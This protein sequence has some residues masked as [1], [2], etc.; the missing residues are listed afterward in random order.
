MLFTQWL[1]E[2]TDR[3]LRKRTGKFAR[4]ARKVS[5]NVPA[6][7]EV[8]ESRV[9]PTITVDLAG[10]TLAITANAAA[11]NLTV[12][13]NGAGTYTLSST[14]DTF[15]DGAGVAI[16]GG[17]TVTVNAVTADTVT[18]NM[19]AGSNDKLVVLST[20]AP[21]SAV[22]GDNSGDTIQGPNGVTAW[23]I[24]ATN[25]LDLDANTATTTDVVTFS[26]FRVAQAGTANDTFNIADSTLQ[27]RGGA[28][29]DTFTLTG[30]LTGSINGEGQATLGGDILTGTSIDN[31]TLT[32]FSASGLGVSGNENSISGGF[33]GIDTITPSAP[34][35]SLTGIG[36][37]SRW[38]LNGTT[39]T[40]ATVVNGIVT[41]SLAVTGFTSLNGGSAV[42]TFNVTGNNTFNVDGGAGN[43]VINIG[44]KVGTTVTAGQLVGTANGGAGNDTL[45]AQNSDGA[46]TLFGGD[47]NDVLIG[48]PQSD[49]LDGGL[50]ADRLYGL[51]DD[52]V[53]TGGAGNDVLDG[54]TG[55]DTVVEHG[56]VII[57]LGVPVEQGISGAIVTNTKITGGQGTDA[58]TGVENLDLLGN[59]GNNLLD[60][61]A[62][63]LGSVTINGG[64]GN[65]TIA[66]GS[67]GDVLDGG[68]DTVG[69]FTDVVR[70]NV[71]GTVTLT[72]TGLTS[73]SVL[74]SLSNFDAASLTGSASDDVI[75]ATTFAGATTINGGAGNDR[76]D[77]AIG[78][79][80]LNGM[81][82]NDTVSGQGGNDSIL[83]GAGNDLLDGGT[84]NDRVNGND[85]DD[86]ITGGAGDDTITGDGGK[87]SI[88]G[89]L[90]DDKIDG[91]DSNDTLMG[92]EDS[93]SITGGAG[94]DSI[95][96]NAGN[97]TLN[98][99]ADADRIEAGDGDDKV[100]GGAGNDVMLGGLGND[101]ISSQGGN[102]TMLGEAGN[103]TLNGGAGNELMY[104]GD[105]DDSMNGMAGNDTMLGDDGD[106]T[107]LGGAGNDLILG[108]KGG[109]D[110]I[111]GQSG[112]DSVSGGG[113]QDTVIDGSKERIDNF[114]H[115]DKDD[116]PDSHDEFYSLYENLDFNDDN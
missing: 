37:N 4:K 2:L 47:G 96:G 108:G 13:A 65:D 23:T 106:D 60:A 115:N 79:N 27:I 5:R 15:V 48:T 11:N 99:N 34:A 14:S 105:D 102:D 70:A 109:D 10:T 112:N 78:N 83:G 86:T 26:G 18:I 52:D 8:L 91:G 82:G 63:T 93:D 16:A 25:T 7:S 59:S 64:D 75:V 97:D 71:S 103:D 46:V 69:A 33:S 1:N 61:S 12:S 6:S 24:G 43:D 74:D 44:T 110:Y 39:A 80:S 95:E 85:G 62:F 55:T 88:T 92:N 54:G 50:G 101:E 98:G 53:L 45:D 94:F 100:F 104:G 57:V 68:V 56:V 51:G 114:R 20:D 111:N 32:S 41:N 58:L 22:G 40:Y 38:T 90:G 29:D 36:V 67:G 84:G 77:G 81:S 30:T 113:G 87:D 72:D 19:G 3:V 116:T 21:I 89:G 66:G 28:G 42:D 76:I 31:V 9:V 73:S 49:L 107:M 35:A 17:N